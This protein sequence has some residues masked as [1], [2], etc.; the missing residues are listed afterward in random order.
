MNGG[1]RWST[2]AS[3]C[4]YCHG[5]PAPADRCAMRVLPGRSGSGGDAPDAAEMSR[6]R[7]ATAGSAPTRQPCNSAQQRIRGPLPT[8]L[9]FTGWQLF[10]TA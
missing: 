3:S 6:R 5:A 4:P 8:D 1:P 9:R 10:F 7:R 2:V